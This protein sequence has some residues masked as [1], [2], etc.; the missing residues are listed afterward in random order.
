MTSFLLIL[1]LPLL[2][3]SLPLVL[4]F[5]ICN[6]TSIKKSTPVTIISSV[7][8][9]IASAWT[10]ILA[11]QL[12][13]YGMTLNR[14]DGKVGCVTGVVLFLFIG[15]ITTILTFIFGILLSYR[16]YQFNKTKTLTI[17]NS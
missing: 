17:D 4:L 13:I 6:L 15:G 9:T 8:L 3:E 1:I 5:V 16:N 11:M 2:I 7:V 12:S 14:P 10:T